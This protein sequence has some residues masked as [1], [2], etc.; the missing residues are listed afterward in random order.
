MLAA[1]S[2]KPIPH[3]ELDLALTPEQRLRE[4]ARLFAI[5]LARLPERGPADAWPDSEKP[6]NSSR[7]DLNSCPEGASLS[8][9][10]VDAAETTE[11][12]RWRHP[13]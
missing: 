9:P 8:L 10:A 7:I 11:T 6:L 13:R 5:G 4:V 2:H 1:E 3:D 12:T